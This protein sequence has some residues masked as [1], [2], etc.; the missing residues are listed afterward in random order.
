M[1][2]TR[3]PKTPPSG[4]MSLRAFAR[5]L[6]VALSAVQRAIADGRLPSAR[7]VKGRWTIPDAERAGG[8]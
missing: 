4:P 7:K 8:A 5:S 2:T 6:G 1:S 3:P